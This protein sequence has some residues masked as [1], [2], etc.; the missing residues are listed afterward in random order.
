MKLENNTFGKL[1]LCL[2]LGLALS[3]PLFEGSKN[4]LLAFCLGFFLYRRFKLESSLKSSV[5]SQILLV[6]FVLSA[7]ASLGAIYKEYDVKKI[8]DIFRYTLIGYIFVKTPLSKQSIY[9]IL[10]VF[11]FSALIASSFAYYSI[12]IGSKPAFE[13]NSVGHINHSSIYLLLIVGLMLPFFLQNLAV[14]KKNIYKLLFTVTTLTLVLILFDTDSR[15]TFIGFWMLLVVV[16]LLDFSINKKI[17]IFLIMFAAF[18]VSWAL[19]SPPD[20]VSKFSVRAAQVE[21]HENKMSPRERIWYTA[22]AVWKKEP[23]FGIGF[24]NFSVITPQKMQELYSGHIEKAPDG[25]KLLYKSHHAHN[26]YVNTLVEGGVIGL[27]ALI[28][29]LVGSGYLFLRKFK[30]AFDS[31]NPSSG[32]FWL[33]GTNSLLIVSVVGLFNTTIHHEHG[34]LAIILIAISCNYNNKLTPNIIESTLSHKP[35]DGRYVSEKVR[36]V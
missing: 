12:S 22:V 3:L 18:Y 11:I 33:I 24:G 34:M 30:Y 35:G 10:S 32:I 7:I 31:S 15:A 26:R 20:V 27:L 36:V 1:E 9:L 4:V 23:I 6:F 13:L 25:N 19:V 5:L 17:N 16:V 21:N 8:H 2:F 28:I 14:F 29:F